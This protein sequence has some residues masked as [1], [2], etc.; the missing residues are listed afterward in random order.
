MKSPNTGSMHDCF[1]CMI[2]TIVTLNS[3]QQI[4]MPF[5]QVH[6]CVVHRIALDAMVC[7]LITMF[8][9]KIDEFGG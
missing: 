4:K 8:P 2:N 9:S 1:I 3:I 6:N 5:V 7:L